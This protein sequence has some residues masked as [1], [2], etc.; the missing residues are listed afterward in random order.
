MKNAAKKKP[1]PD[2]A[3]PS[4]P[5]DLPQQPIDLVDDRDLAARTP[6]ARIT[7]QTWRARGKGPPFYQIGRRRLYRWSEVLV[8]LESQ[9]IVPKAS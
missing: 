8:W 2:L 3:P 9:R 4:P 1:A 6:I 5:A 7:W